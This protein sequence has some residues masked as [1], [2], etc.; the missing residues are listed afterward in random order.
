MALKVRD[1]AV[2]EG[3]KEAVAMKS[4][5]TALEMIP[6]IIASN[7]GYD[8]TELVADLK[9]AIRKNEGFM[10]LDMENGKVTCMKDFGIVESYMVSFFLQDIFT[11]GR[12]FFDV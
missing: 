6:H 8:A 3:G 7:A 5:A 10:G 9:A 2:E 11:N 12:I 4:F 1:A